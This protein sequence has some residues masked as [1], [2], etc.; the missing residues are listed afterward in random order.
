MKAIEKTGAP[1]APAR[2]DPYP[3]G[4]VD[5]IL[6]ERGGSEPAAKLNPDP[7]TTHSPT[8]IQGVCW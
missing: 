2:S 6:A 1:K 8:E 3:K 7:R 4:P 5:V